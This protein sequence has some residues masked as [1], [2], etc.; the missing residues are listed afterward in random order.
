MKSLSLKHYDCKNYST[1]VNNNFNKYDF[2]RIRNE[3]EDR[4]IYDYGCLLGC[5]AV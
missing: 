2:T 5:S 3:V 1:L 4:M